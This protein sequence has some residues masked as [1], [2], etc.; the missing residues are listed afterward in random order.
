ME[1]TYSKCWFV[2]L[3]VQHAMRMRHFVVYGLSGCTV[4]S[5]LSH[6][7]HDLLK[8]KSYRTQKCVF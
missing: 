2:A 6:K 5:T 3:S 4:F 8:K 1:I 7:R